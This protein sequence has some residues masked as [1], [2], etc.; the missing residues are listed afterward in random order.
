MS[1]LKQAHQEFKPT[2]HLPHPSCVPESA[3]YA[4]VN[5]C[6]FFNRNSILNLRN[7]PSKDFR[8]ALVEIFFKM[9]IVVCFSEPL[10]MLQKYK[11][12]CRH[13]WYLC[14]KSQQHDSGL[15]GHG[16]WPIPQKVCPWQ[17]SDSDIGIVEKS[18]SATDHAVSIQPWK[19]TFE[20][21]GLLTWQFSQT[22]Y[23]FTLL[24]SWTHQRAVK[25]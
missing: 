1:S 19:R 6:V 23:L 2:S 22:L 14:W 9:F 8:P 18:C 15:D 24:I 20:T 10:S 11:H 4:G 13:N 25:R 7:V 21:V 17:S 12:H 3:G 5:F 16:D